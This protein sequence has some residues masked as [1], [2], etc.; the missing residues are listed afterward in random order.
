RVARYAWPSARFQQTTTASRLTS[1]P[2]SSAGRSALAGS[3]NS[4]EANR[5]PSP[6]P[7]SRRTVAAA[8]RISSAVSGS[9]GWVTSVPSFTGVQSCRLSPGPGHPSGAGA[10]RLVDLVRHRPQ[11]QNG[12]LAGQGGSLRVGPRGHVTDLEAAVS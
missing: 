8:W 2:D 11:A 3:F 1:S 9:S 6:I 7:R 10:W 12:L 4:I 5:Q